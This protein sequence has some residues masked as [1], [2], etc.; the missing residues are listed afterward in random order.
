MIE[1]HDQQ[2]ASSGIIIPIA[3]VEYHESLPWEIDIIIVTNLAKAL[4]ERLGMCVAPPINYGYVKRNRLAISPTLDVYINYMKSIIRQFILLGFNKI[5]LYSSTG[6][7]G[8]DALRLIVDEFIDS[9]PDVKIILCEWTHIAKVCAKDV[10]GE[11]PLDDILHS[12]AIEQSLYKLYSGDD[13]NVSKE[14]NNK[15][16]SDLGF[17]RVYANTKFDG[18]SVGI[19][20]SKA[21]KQK[22]KWISNFITNYNV[23]YIKAILWDD[24]YVGINNRPPQFVSILSDDTKLKLYSCKTNTYDVIDKLLIHY[25][26]EN[27]L[28]LENKKVLLKPN[29]GFP[30]QNPSITHPK[31]IL[32]VINTLVEYGCD[33]DN[34]SICEG[35][36]IPYNLKF[37]FEKNG[38][39]IN[40]IN[41]IDINDCKFVRVPVNGRI[42]DYVDL[43][44]ILYAY[45]ILINLPVLKEHNYTGI[46]GALKN[47]FGLLPPYER[48]R[49]HSLVGSGFHDAL[50]DINSIIKPTFTIMDAIN[51]MLRAPSLKYGGIPKFCG[52]II[53][54]NESGLVDFYGLT[55]LNR[56]NRKDAR[57]E[58]HEILH[59][60]RYIENC[61][62]EIYDPKLIKEVSVND[63]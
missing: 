21:S 48:V 62:I 29:F 59:L 15:N 2:K 43:P 36:T 39:N 31:L 32:N 38:I 34:I 6:R 27:K 58:Y 24:L 60:K 10:F 30:E 46:T 61:G 47:I 51:V 3:H 54:S 25:M 44:E 8:F 17:R 4:A 16:L 42:L 33:L 28:D 9:F 14:E 50:A 45:D 35:P 55:L 22:G 57:K 19:A 49:I 12:D 53:I 40:K 5:V 20:P 13:K 11:S 56:L 26:E 23:A 7:E 41:I 1:L 37:I 52:Y 18:E 63:L